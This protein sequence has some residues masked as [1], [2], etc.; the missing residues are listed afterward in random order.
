MTTA[1]YFATPET[2]LPRELAFGV[3]RVADAPTVRHQRV[4]LDL[5]LTLTPQ[6]RARRLG[7][8]FIAPM[9]VVLDA[10][11][12]LVVQPDLLVVSPRRSQL[13]GDR[14]Y[15]PPDLAIEVLSPHPRI[16]KL[17]ERLGWFS[18][19]G[20][21]ECWLASTAEK[22]IAVLSLNERGV[23]RQVV[24]TGSMRIESSVLAGVEVT[25]L[26]IFGY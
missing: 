21:L 3:L 1:E 26:D 9:D 20:V 12:H 11:R 16:G 2:V 8:L 25:P 18:S 19:Y 13:V 7:E 24:Y 10:D 5:A 17:D 22:E 14:V 23:A 15:G 4:V 6:V